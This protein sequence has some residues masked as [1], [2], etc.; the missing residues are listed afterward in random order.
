MTKRG[1][2]SKLNFAIPTDDILDVF[3][4]FYKEYASSLQSIS[5]Y[6]DKVI[7]TFASEIITPHGLC[8][9]FNLAF[10]QDVLELNATSNDFYYQL[11]YR[12][13]AGHS[14][15][16]RIKLPADFPLKSKPDGLRIHVNTLLRPEQVV[17]NDFGGHCFMLHDPFELPTKA[18]YTVYTDKSLNVLMHAKINSIDDSLKHHKPQ[19]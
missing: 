8:L 10:S 5:H 18:S 13:F 17:Q 1:T 15:T 2:F 9:A 11:V 14:K 4:Q 3:N 12:I 16:D 6:F 19:E 7:K